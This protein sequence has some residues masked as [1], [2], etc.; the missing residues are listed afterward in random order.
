MVNTRE[1]IIAKRSY[2]FP[3]HDASLI[4]V[5]FNIIGFFR[6]NLGAY[7]GLMWLLGGLHSAIGGAFLVFVCMEGGREATKL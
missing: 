1:R 6:D 5:L 4:G 7:D 3:G 2:F